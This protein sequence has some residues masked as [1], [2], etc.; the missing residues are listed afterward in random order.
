MLNK[1][2]LCLDERMTKAAE[3][4]PKARQRFNKN[5]L[6]KAS[7]DFCRK[8]GEEWTKVASLVFVACFGRR[9]LRSFEIGL[10]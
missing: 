4:L 9:K 3:R 8:M 2:F 6:P 10:V 7:V 1:I 5:G